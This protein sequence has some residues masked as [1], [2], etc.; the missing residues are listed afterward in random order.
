MTVSL[1]LDVATDDAAA[2]GQKAA[3]DEH[4]DNSFHYILG[5]SVDGG[6]YAVTN[7]RQNRAIWRSESDNLTVILYINV[8]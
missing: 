5:L 8:I 4:G 7:V 2:A 1:S 6:S 3:D